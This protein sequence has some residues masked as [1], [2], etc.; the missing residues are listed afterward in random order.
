MKRLFFAGVA[1]AVLSGTAFAADLPQRPQVY[2]KAPAYV[3]P[4]AYNWTGFYLGINGG[5]GFGNSSFSGTPGTGNFD[6]NGGMVGGTLGYNWQAGQMVY[7]L[8]TD[9]DWSNILGSAACGAFSCETRNNYLGTARGRIGYAADRWLPYITGGLAYGDVEAR[10]PGIGSASDTRVGWTV[11][12][13]LEYALAQN[14]TVKAE[15]L[16]V[17]LGKF[18]CAAACG[19]TPPDNVDFRSHVVRA[20]LNY[21]F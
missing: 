12:G 10:V 15:Y 6:V 5:Y 9:I 17:D 2:T 16:Y 1:L 7:G 20:G 3:A 13:G 8:E 14:W 21:K 11:G 18:D 19:G 4:I